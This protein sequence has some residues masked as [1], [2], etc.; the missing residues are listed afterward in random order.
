MDCK[1]SRNMFV[2]RRTFDEGKLQRLCK[3]PLPLNE[4]VP[5]NRARCMPSENANK[6]QAFRGYGAH[7]LIQVM[8]QL[9]K[10]VKCIAHNF[11]KYISFSVV[12]FCVSSTAWTFYKEAWI[13]FSKSDIKGNIKNKSNYIKRQQT[14]L[15]KGIYPNVYMNSWNTV[16]ASQLFSS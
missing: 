9:Q 7:H 5:R 8:L 15:Q 11:E 10:Q 4:Q 16:S 13:H 12:G 1:Q 6:T 3:G 2:L 14:A